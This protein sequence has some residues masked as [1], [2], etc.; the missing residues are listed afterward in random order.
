M[1]SSL[2]TTEIRDVSALRSRS[3]VFNV[4]LISRRTLRIA[5]WRSWAAH[6]LQSYTV[7]SHDIKSSEHLYLVFEPSARIELAYPVYKTGTSPCMF[8]G[9]TR[10][11][12]CWDI[13]TQLRRALGSGGPVPSD[14][15]QPG[16]QHKHKRTAIFLS[17]V[18]EEGVEPSTFGVR[19]RRF[20]HWTTPHQII[21]LEHLRYFSLCHI[22]PANC[23]RTRF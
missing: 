11:W 1:L 17:A 4:W 14:L 23:H 13:R 2:S 10:L 6:S 16:E 22:P 9:Q 21:N 18:G 19:N 8:R 7:C 5:S 20:Y 3:S 15:M 12:R